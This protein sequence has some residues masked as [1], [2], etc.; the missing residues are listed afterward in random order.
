MILFLDFDGALHPEDHG[1]GDSSGQAF[2]HLPKLERVLRDHPEVEVVISSMWREQLSLEALRALF[3]PDLA[4]RIVGVTPISPRVDG[5]YLP[6][7][8]EEEIIDWLRQCGRDQ[9]PWLALDDADWQFHRHRESLIACR[10]DV[11]LDDAA[12]TKLRG[13]IAQL[14]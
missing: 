14:T 5:K 1:Q 6:A 3:S 10:S 4:H 8:R 7:R 12:E 9:E 2:C 13:L 11:G